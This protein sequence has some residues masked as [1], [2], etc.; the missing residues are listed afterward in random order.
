[1]NR[2]FMVIIGVL[3]IARGS[4]SCA[5][6]TFGSDAEY[7]SDMPV[8]LSASRLTQALNEAPAAVTVIDR[9]T[10]QA[11][12]ARDLTRL[13]RLVPGMTVGLYNGRRVTLGFHGLSDPYFRQ[14][15]V[16]VD[17]ISIYSPIWGGAEWSE[18]PIAVEDIERLEV[19]R[20]PNAAAFGGNAFLGVVNIITRDPAM[21]SRF[22]AATNVG[23]TGIRDVLVRFAGNDGDLRYRVTA[24]QR[25]DDG[26]D[27]YPDDRRGGFVNLRGHYRLGGQE[28]LRLQ[29]AYSGGATQN[30]NYSNKPGNSNGPRDGNYDAGMLQLRWTRVQGADEEIW[31]Q[32]FHSERSHRETLPFVLEL[33]KAFGGSWD[34][35]LRFGYDH[36]RSD[37]EMQHTLR[38]SET[39]RGVWGVQAREDIARSRAY[40]GTG[41]PQHSS[42]IRLFG[43]A[44]WRLSPAW[45]L[46]GGALREDNNMSGSAV[47]P[48]VS[49]IHQFL[50]GHS[51]RARWAEGRRPPMLYEGRA[52]RYYDLPAG[53]A[54]L[55]RSKG[56]PLADLPLAYS[57][58]AR[59]KLDDER[60][61]SRELSYLG[62][63]PDARL[64]MELHLVEHRVEKL[65]GLYYYPIDTFL[66]AFDAK[67]RSTQGF[68]NNGSA[69]IRAASGALR[70]Q[71]RR[72]TDIRLS[73]ART[74]IDARGPDAALIETSAP[75]HAFSIFALQDLPASWQIGVG[76]YRVGAMRTMG[77]GDLLPPIE[78]VDLRLAKKIRV[79]S[80]S[81]EIALVIQN[82][83]GGG[84][85][86]ERD[87]VD[88]R[89]TWLNVR[90]SY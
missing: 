33:P 57:A 26:L 74:T 27:S 46:S 41:A 5:D 48:N 44:E 39:L 75:H 72:D 59:D 43:T 87:D 23:E 81:A 6:S 7:F 49:V 18:L 1:M 64:E 2:R 34:Y 68:L 85:L 40:F 76:F 84:P 52:D 80:G 20:G 69:R 32:L 63:F 54:S 28:E 88:R 47:S 8:V 65:V 83:T 31:V 90:Y 89:T 22:E 42:F 37:L 56:S 19:V 13:F 25:A 4:P 70:W 10:I 79:G 71:P 15:Q 36:Q 30:G 86:F 73:L 55:L 38:V 60:V 29:A 16:L 53:L 78:R 3:V 77:G 58:L 66:G 50:P 67:Y 82:A 24:G 62:Q 9:R 12:G 61:R 51:L 11:S 45:M 21:E 35:P 14:F 17:G